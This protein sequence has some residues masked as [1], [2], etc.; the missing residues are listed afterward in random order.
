MGFDEDDPE[1]RKFIQHHRET[2]VKGMLDSAFVAQLVSPN[3]KPEEPDVKFAVEIGLSILL[4]KP[5]LA[6]VLPG[7]V[8]PAKLRLVADRVVYCDIDTDEG[9]AVLEAAIDEMMGSGLIHD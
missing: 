9:R 3:V 8:I 2:T 6:V 4:D 5:I 7:S 1:F